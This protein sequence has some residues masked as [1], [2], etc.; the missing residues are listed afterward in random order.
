MASISHDMPTR[1]DD[2]QALLEKIEGVIDNPQVACTVQDD[3]IRRRL[4]EAGRKLSLLMEA[5]GDTIHR[6]SN[7]PLQLVLARIGV[8]TRLFET[9][10]KSGGRS[11]SN[12]ELAQNTGIDSVLMKRFLRYYQSYGMISQP[13]NDEYCSNNITEA[14]ASTAGRSGISYFSETVLPSFTA[15]PR[16]LRET[17]YANSTDPSHCAWH[18]GHQSD[19]SPF[20]WLQSHAEHFEYFLPWM[21]TQRDGLPIFLDVFDFQQELAQGTTDSTAIFVDVGGVVGHQCI[22]LKQRFPTLPGR[23]I[24][25]DQSHIIDQ[26]KQNPLPGFEGIEAEPYDF[27]TPQP[28]EGARAYYMRN[29]LH[30]WPDDK[31][32]EIL[33]NVKAGMTEQSVLLIDEM[34]LSERGAPWRATQLDMAMMTCLAAK[35]R[36]EP[37]WRALLDDA[38]YEISKIWKYTEECEDC[39]LVAVPK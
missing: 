16:F 9:L 13:S 7:T 33:H 6:I 30:D 20:P 5:P 38:G 25:Q 3:S 14:L 24:L 23:I 29:I 36:S 28:I 34:V 11:L 8:E 31:C 27:F 22:A 21:A 10:A 2:V 37:E 15:F 12:R 17:G 1:V 4:R 32:K 26:V 35:E 18:V 39:V 19:L